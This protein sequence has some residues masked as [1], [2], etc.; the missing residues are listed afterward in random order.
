[1][2]KIIL[3][4]F[5]VYTAFVAAYL[6]RF[7]YFSDLFPP[8][9]GI[10]RSYSET[11]LLVVVLWLAIFKLMGLY[12][13]KRSSDLLDEL[14]LIIFSVIIASGTLLGFLFIYR[15]LWFS[16]VVVIMAAV[17]A[18]ALMWLARF[19]LKVSRRWLYS[20]G[21]GRYRVLIVGAGEMGQT[22][23]LKL[24]IDKAAGGVPVGYL[25]DD[26][27]AAGKTFEGIP[28][29]GQIPIIRNIIKEHQID[30]VI[31]ASDN[32]PYQRILDIVTECEVLRVK[33]KIVPGILEIIASRVNIE[34]IGG[35]PLV[36]ISEIGLTGIK[37]VLKRTMD[38]SS[39]AILLTA[40]SPIYLLIAALIKIDSRGS[41]FYTQER[42]GKDGQT[43]PMYKFR[44]M[45]V[46]AEKMVDEL[47]KF[48]ETEGHIFKIKK[49]PRLTRIGKWLRR[50]SIDEWPQ[51][52][53]VIKGD[54][55][56]VGPRPPL[57]REVV[58]YSPWHMKRLRVSPGISGLWQVSG[59]SLLPFE[60]MVRLDIYYIE[61]WSLWLDLKILI[62]TIPAVLTASGAF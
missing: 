12:E 4:A 2:V 32:L 31:F 9:Q 35:I 20:R 39:A 40:L 56:L 10:F 8:A 30:E 24:K 19:I 38:L 25:D 58:K 53:N 45:V 51:L 13:E 21:V 44:S 29:L 52:F 27:A 16:R 28:V 23:A 34:D 47:Q 36:T 37:S 61:N 62:R 1:V 3:D 42:V 59:R 57:P 43:F 49:D 55:S 15:G 33:F 50:L 18:V 6:L 26:P 7:D 22:L 17:I 60:D 5:V 48:S 46:G 11:L 14:A 54:M 41:V